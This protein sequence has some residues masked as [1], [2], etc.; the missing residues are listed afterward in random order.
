MNGKLLRSYM[1]LHND[2]NQTLADYL[3]ISET[4]VSNKINENGTEFKQGE[5]ALIKARYS[6]T[7]EEVE[8]IFFN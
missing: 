7:A 6:L 4:S 5:I 8:N 1:V 3:D 2:T